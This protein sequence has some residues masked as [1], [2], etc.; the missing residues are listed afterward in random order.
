MPPG[1]GRAPVRI[2]AVT[3][4]STVTARARSI[5]EETGGGDGERGRIGDGAATAARTSRTARATIARLAIEW[6]KPAVAAIAA[7]TTGP[8]RVVAHDTALY[9]QSALIIDGAAVAT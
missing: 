8:G 4:Q 6:S 2:A 9:R 1:A 5:G 7:A 3:T